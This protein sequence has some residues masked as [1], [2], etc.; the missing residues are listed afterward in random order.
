M[1]LI[2]PILD[3]R[4][5]RAA[6]RRAASSGSRST[7]R[8][9]PTTTR[10][11]PGIALLELFAYLG[12]SLLYRFNQIPDTTKIEFLRLLGVQPR[13]P[14]SATALLAA[15]DRAC[16]RRADPPRAPRP[17]PDRSRSRPTTRST[18]GRSTALAVGKMPAPAATASR[19]RASERPPQDA[20]DRL[21]GAACR[22][23]TRR[24]PT[25]LR[26]DAA[27]RRPDRARTPWR[28]TS[29]R[30]LDQSLWIA[31][32]RKKTTDVGAARA[33]QP[34][35]SA[36]PSTSSGCPAR[37]TCRHRRGPGTADRFA[38]VGLTADPPPMLWRLWN[39]PDVGDRAMSRC[40]AIGA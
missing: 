11:I 37:S 30:P 33:A 19:R 27:A 12:E 8:S 38:D 29:A 4:T 21:R 22:P 10:A 7:R 23:P 24:M 3:D 25:F 40:S 26:H 32:L 39:G 5:L 16:R 18:S 2:S 14:R 20:E 36:S 35:S 9:G 17:A 1:A 31:V 28:S 15:T 13:P 34:V 6:A